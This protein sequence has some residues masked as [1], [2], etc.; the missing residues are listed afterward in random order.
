MPFHEGAQQGGCLLEGTAF[1]GSGGGGLRRGQGDVI[2]SEA[3]ASQEVALAIVESV[4]GGELAVQLG[5]GFH[6]VNH[7][8]AA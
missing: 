3:E 5:A 4:P 6:A 7:V 8:V 2:G 1:P